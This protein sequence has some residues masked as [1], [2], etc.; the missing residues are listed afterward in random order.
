MESPIQKKNLWT[1][2]NGG[3]NCKIEY[4]SGTDNSVADLPSR[5]PNQTVD[6]DES[7]PDDPDIS[8]KTYEISALNSNRFNPKDFARFRPKFQDEVIK[9]TLNR[10]LNMVEEQEKDEA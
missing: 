7:P 9:P 5:V 2:S 4:L 1:L 8:A 6:L 10:S 3:Y